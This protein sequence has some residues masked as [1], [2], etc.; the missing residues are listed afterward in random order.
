[1]LSRG[2]RGAQHAAVV[3]L[4]FSALFALLFS[5]VLG[6]GGLLGTTDAVI[7]YYPAWATHHF[8]WTPNLYAGYPVQGDPQAMFWYPLTWATRAL[9]VAR[10]GAGTGGWNVFVVSAYVLAASFAYGYAYRLTASR[11][12]ACVAGLAY[13]MSGFAIAHLDHVSII[14]TLA[15]APLVVWA[16]EEQRSCANARWLAVG[17]FGVGS[18]ALAGHPQT[19]AYLLGIA[20][21]YVLVRGKGAEVGRTRYTLGAV[22][23]F[24][25]GAALAAAMLVPMFE[26]AEQSLRGAMTRESFFLYALD[27]AQLPQLI[28]P[29][30]FGG[31][32]AVAGDTLGLPYFGP[33]IP[34]E[35]IGFAGVVPLALAGLACFLFLGG[36]SSARDS[37]VL[38]RFWAGVAVVSLLLALGDHAWLSEPLFY[39][40]GYNR[41]R[42]PT[43]HLF[44]LSLALAMLAALGIAAL[45]GVTAER[46]RQLTRWAAL[47]GVA[48]MLAAS[49]S[50]AIAA[51]EGVFAEQMYRAGVT[52]DEAMPWLNPGVLVQA[53]AAVL[54]LATLFAWGHRGTRLASVALVVTV[55]L[56]LGSYAAFAGWRMS[57]R[58]GE[59]I[60]MPTALEPLRAELASTGQR[61]TALTFDAPNAS[62]PPNRNDLWEIPGALGY[63]PLPLADY[64]KL[65]GLS[66]AHF[67]DPGELARVLGT[68]DRSLDVLATRYVLVPDDTATSSTRARR[69]ELLRPTREGVPQWGSIRD[70]LARTP[71]WSRGP[72]LPGTAVYENSRAQPRAWVVGDVAVASQQQSRE[73]IRTGKLANGTRFDP[74][75]LALVEEPVPGRRVCTSDCGA[76]E[77]VRIEDRE[78]IVQATATGD[79]FLVLADVHY[80]GWRVWV[81]DEPA[82]LYRTNSCLRG[83]ALPSGTHVVRFGFEPTSFKVGAAL[84]AASMLALAGLLL[85]SWAQSSRRTD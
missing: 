18:A 70:F 83:V 57:A 72:G 37:V 81:D 63:G 47:L 9:G 14:H 50:F 38:A 36:R 67:A 71:R 53:A 26:L 80:P 27:W 2:A 41:F 4:G 12:A 7:Y 22:A 59:S 16:L 73:V 6:T 51:R 19:F 15:W 25:L 11:Y 42:I 55:A 54:A 3:V 52:S 69:A 84:S 45:E 77:I 23:C 30:V 43:R 20:F 10:D 32:V 24:A 44:E 5:P 17:A 78:V 82:K 60:A 34:G 61:L 75:A 8:G 76:A 58:P 49:A 40:P 68:Q 39:L 28:L 1:V 21:A 85:V 56:D 74:A 48:T 65:L 64:A 35:V 31:A 13:G 79:A 33:G 66:S 29:Y 46:R 62:A